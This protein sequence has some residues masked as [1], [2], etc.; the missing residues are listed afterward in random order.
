MIHHAPGVAVILRVPQRLRDE[1]AHNRE[2]NILKGKESP[3]RSFQDMMDSD[4]NLPDS[5]DDLLFEQFFDP[6]QRT[7]LFPREWIAGY[8]DQTTLEFTPNPHYDPDLK[9]PVKS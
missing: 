9:D 2:Q 3:S 8:A 6:Q 4:D 5:L 7:V 1:V